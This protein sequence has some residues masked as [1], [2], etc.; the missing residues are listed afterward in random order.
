MYV[1]ENHKSGVYSILQMKSQLRIWYAGLF[2][3]PGC[4][5][6]SSRAKSKVSYEVGNLE[7]LDI[8]PN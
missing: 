6:Q 1:K 8:E 3:K 5:Y 7:L 4:T 2:A